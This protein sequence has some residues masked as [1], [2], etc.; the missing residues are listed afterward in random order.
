[1]MRVGGQSGT[2][3]RSTTSLPYAGATTQAAAPASTAQSDAAA[4]VGSAVLAICRFLLFHFVEPPF[5][6]VTL[7]G[8]AHRLPVMRAEDVNLYWI[9]GDRER[10]ARSEIGRLLLA[11]HEAQDV[12]C[13]FERDD[14]HVAQRLDEM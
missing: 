7:D 9:D 1:M 5:F 3:M 6:H 8:S 10:V 13:A 4:N 2:A 12:A 11:Q 14:R